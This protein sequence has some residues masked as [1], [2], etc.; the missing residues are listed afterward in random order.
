MN[1]I[2]LVL[3]ILT[4]GILCYIFNNNM[5]FTGQTGGALPITIK[6]SGPHYLRHYRELDNVNN[7][8]NR[9]LAPA[10][11]ATSQLHAS[12]IWEDRSQLEYIK[13]VEKYLKFEDYA[14]EPVAEDTKTLVEAKQHYFL[15]EAKIIDYYGKK[16]YWD[17]R[18]PR[19]PLPVE[20]AKDADK[21]VKEHPNLYP[22]YV[23]SSRNYSQLKNNDS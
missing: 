12:N 4:I 18:Y 7:V 23:I 20:F 15:D 5:G 8:L 19:E 3:L 1:H 16:Y 10:D 13:P 11:K 6:E 21:W 14:E 2:N 9:P 17:W 22:S